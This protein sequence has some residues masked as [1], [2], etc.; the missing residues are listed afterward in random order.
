MW[1]ALF[2]SFLVWNISRKES[3]FLWDRGQNTQRN[4]K[5][6]DL[7]TALSPFLQDH[8]LWPFWP[9]ACNNESLWF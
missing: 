3:L 1:E 9:I 6:F 2:A 5:A 4:L 7:L 8:F